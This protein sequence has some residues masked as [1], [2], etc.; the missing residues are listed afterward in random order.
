MKAVFAAGVVAAALALASCQTVEHP[1]GQVE[2][3]IMNDVTLYNASS[4][5]I[6]SYALRPTGSKEWFEAP[7]EHFIPSGERVILLMP[8]DL[9]ICRWDVQITGENGDVSTYRD[10][11]FCNIRNLRFPPE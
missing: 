3:G 8:K 11:D 10:K 4:S 7:S 1:L 6:A 2:G 9:P 5:S